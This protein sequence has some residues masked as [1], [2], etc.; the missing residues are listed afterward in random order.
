[1][2]RQVGKGQRNADFER[3]IIFDGHSYRKL[4]NKFKLS[5]E[6]LTSIKYWIKIKGGL[7]S[8]VH[9]KWDKKGSLGV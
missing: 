8:L 4:M 9:K 2:L 7:Q 1:V 6:K 3:A 5:S